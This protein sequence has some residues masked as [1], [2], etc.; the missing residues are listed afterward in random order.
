MGLIPCLYYGYGPRLS[1]STG[2][3]WLR[4]VYLVADNPCTGGPHT[5]VL[6]MISGS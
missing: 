4:H 6:G 5:N 1:M 3:P 2:I